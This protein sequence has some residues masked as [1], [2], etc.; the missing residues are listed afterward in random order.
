MPEHGKPLPVSN[1][2]EIKNELCAAI[3]ELRQPKRMDAS[4]ITLSETPELD[5]KNF[6]N[7]LMSQC[8]RAEIRL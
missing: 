1:Q 3:K 4:Q 6:Y 5:V 7:A 2:E 8:P